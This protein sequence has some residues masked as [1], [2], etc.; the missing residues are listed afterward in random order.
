MADDLGEDQYHIMVIQVKGPLTK[1]ALQDYVEAVQE[2]LDEHGAEVQRKVR[3]LK[4][5]QD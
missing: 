3:V 4:P 2:V 5:R 1:Q